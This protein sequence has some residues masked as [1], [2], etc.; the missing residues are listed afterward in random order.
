MGSKHW[1][2]SP[3]RS[4]APSWRT[5]S[6]T[7]P[8]IKAGAPTQTERYC[9]LPM[10]IFALAGSRDRLRRPLS[11]RRRLAQTPS[12]CRRM[13]RTAAIRGRFRRLRLALLLQHLRRLLLRPR[14]LRKGAAAVAP[15]ATATSMGS[16]DRTTV[17]SAQDPMAIK[18]MRA[19]AR[20]VT[21]LSS[22]QRPR[23]RDRHRSARVVS[24]LTRS[25]R[26]GISAA[27]TSRA[28]GC[29]LSLECSRF[30]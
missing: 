18:V 20:R 27:A 19:T 16:S 24:L 1:Q 29:S 9:R 7:R 14:R 10:V 12:Q 26:R 22:A 21:I 25:S 5:G 13:R 23:R 11:V 28:D 30:P 4:G 2:S 17:A 6:P 3:V 8:R 15:R